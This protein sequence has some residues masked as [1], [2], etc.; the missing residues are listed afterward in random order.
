MADSGFLYLCKAQVGN[1]N[2]TKIKTVYVCAWSDL[3]RCVNVT[4]KWAFYLVLK[5]YTQTYRATLGEKG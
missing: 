2:T 4:I 3:P 1:Q 5:K